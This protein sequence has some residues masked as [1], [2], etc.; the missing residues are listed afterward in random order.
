MEVIVAPRGMR[1]CLAHKLVQD[2]SFAH[3]WLVHPDGGECPDG[4]DSHGDSARV[5]MYEGIRVY[6]T[7][8][9]LECYHR[10]LCDARNDKRPLFRKTRDGVIRPTMDD[11]MVDMWDEEERQA[12]IDGWDKGGQE[13]P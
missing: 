10:G 6:F 5:A 3:M 7:T 9:V 12:Y 13:I 8:R 2:N 4:C 11:H 1:Q